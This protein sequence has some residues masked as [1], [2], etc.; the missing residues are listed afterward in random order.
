MAPT[1]VAAPLLLTDPGYLF[2]APLA[3]TA[4]TNTV[5]GSVFTDAWAAAWIPLG[6]TED[7]TELH[8]QTNVE[9]ITV[10]EFFDPIKYATTSRA[11]SVAFN[12]ANWTLS[13]Y[14]RAL[15]GGTAA[16]V[17]TTGTGATSLF[18]LTPPTPGAEVRCMLGWESLDN[19][20]RL[21]AYQTIQGGE[22]V[23]AF[24]KAPDKGL[25]PCTFNFEVPASGIP[26]SLFA[27]G[28]ARGG[29]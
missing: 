16:L 28:V 26:F 17:A 12:L 29:T 18:T 7:G 9:A 24:H 1:A 21:I 22:V 27:A 4:P 25:I 8:Y 14:R 10:A 5:A 19:T 3:T 6:A 13:N 23:S 2:I 11:G 20:V 15:N